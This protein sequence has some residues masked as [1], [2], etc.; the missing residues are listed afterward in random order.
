VPFVVSAALMALVTVLFVWRVR[1]P[2]KGEGQERESLREVTRK[3]RGLVREKPQLAWLVAANA[4]WEL[5]VAALKTFVVLYI[6]VGLGKSS[7][8]ASGVLAVV[9]VM[10]V[11]AALLAGKFGDRIGPVPL[12]RAA[13][14]V[15]AIG[16]LP[17]L[18][19]QS[20]WLIV[21]VVPAAFAAGVIMT[22]PYAEMM[23]QL[24]SEHHG[25]AAGVFGFSRGV[26][27][28]LGPVLAGVAVMVL[29]G[30][31]A[32][33]H[34]YA[35]VFGVASVAVFVSIACLGRLQ[36]AERRH[37]GVRPQLSASADR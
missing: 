23:G 8:I 15:Y 6:T 35:A 5:T 18:F 7:S 26:G 32:S 22:L 11:A 9:A 34:G 27:T 24:E 20:G 13:A 29:K 21:A 3:V 37:S 17:P 19:I 28:I 30:P 36:R 14:W 10:V 31:L 33:T 4:L 1:D 16:L 12:M 2:R 25:A